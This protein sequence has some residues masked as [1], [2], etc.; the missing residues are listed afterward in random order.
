MIL[1]GNGI[2]I[3]QNSENPIIYNGAIVIDNNMIKEV[4]DYDYLKNKY[5]NYDF[6]DAKGK[7]I[8][9]GLI[10]THHHIYSAFARGM[11]NRELPPVDFN[12]IL[13]K[14]WWKMDKKLTLKD[15]KYSAYS[16]LIDSI[17]NGVT[18]VFD[19][20]ASPNSIGSSLFTIAEVSKELGIRT[21]LCYEVSDRDGEDILNQGISEN[22]N[23][24][25]YANNDDT[26]MIRGLFGLHASFTLSDRSLDKCVNSL[27]G[28]KCG[29]HVHTAEG[30]KDQ[31][32]CIKNSNM[33][34]VERFEK[35]GLLGEKTLAVHCVHIDEKEMD[36]L[37]RTKTN[38]INNPESNMG[39][40][41]GCSKVLEMLN[42][43]I[44][45]GMGTDGYTSDMFE[46]MK[47]FPIIQRHAR[48]N[49]SVAF[50]ETFTLLF[51]NNRKIASNYFSREI[52]ILKE[53]AYAD[54][55]IVDYN[56]LT[57]M[58]KDNL[59]GH[60]LFGFTGR[61]VRTSI[62]NGKVVMKDREL[63][64]IDEEEIF[65]RS[66]KVAQKLWDKM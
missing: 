47:V 9:P 4:G 60:F 59:Y 21:S 5:E 16:T 56:P 62:I 28:M 36:I 27:E 23:F 53:G 6:I 12:D 41:V 20:H 25:K 32:E 13:D 45:V 19:H 18:T 55:I 34:I 66:R 26:D 51:D 11:N 3:T 22:L 37:S 33:R 57:P 43:G 17:K 31:E 39:N 52:G 63:T 8:M 7:V 30:I 10:N 14:L 29:F 35:F 42:K 1:V 49:P 2:V 40:A 24:I 58:T 61:T 50:N 64:N 54:L 48:Q 38:V 44:R 15:T 46:S 65:N